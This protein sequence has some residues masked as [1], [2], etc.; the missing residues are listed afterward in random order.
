MTIPYELLSLLVVLAGIGQL[1]LCVA[2][3]FIP[4]VLRWPEQ[5]T[6]LPKLLRQVF[7]TYSAYILGAHLLFAIVSV[8]APGWLMDGSGPARILSGMIAGW[9]GARLLIHLSGYDTS[10]VPSH[11]WYGVAKHALGLLFVSLTV[12][13]LGAFLYNF[14][15]FG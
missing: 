12:V 5:L 14:G 4:L 6:A 2:S 10:E 13:Y 11:G 8:W 15:V 9:W 7:W 1:I 3:P